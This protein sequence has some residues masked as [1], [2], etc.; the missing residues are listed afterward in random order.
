M[1][2]NVGNLVRELRKMKGLTQEKLAEGICS[3]STIL[4]IEKGERKPDWFT[5]RNIMARLGE[6]PNKF[7]IEIADNEETFVV[8][9]H[10]EWLAYIRECDYESMKK[11]IELHKND[12]RFLN[13]RGR[14][15]FLK[16]KTC[17]Y[18]MG[19]YMDCQIAIECAL[20]SIRLTRP[21]F[22][23]NNI[24]TYFLAPHEIETIN[25]LANAYS[26]HDEPEMSLKI[27]RL[28]KENLGLH[29][30]SFLNFNQFYLLILVNLAE[31]L[32]RLD[33]LN[34][35]LEVCAEGMEVS[36]GCRDMLYYMNFVLTKAECLMKLGNK[37]EG[38]ELFKQVM[39][40]SYA[41]Q[42]KTGMDFNEIAADYM[43]K[44]NEKI[45]LSL[46]WPEG[47]K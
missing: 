40:F 41:T 23:I 28:L 10:L 27:L 24:N 2:F 44:Y 16:L 20:E 30:A 39:L 45:D 35:S 38:K 3:R 12:K 9:K 1:L 19:P 31:D 34:E 5:F 25:N 29:Y 11:E 37:T 18:N 43:E 36:L 17:F 21:D 6:D 47:M 32:N 15:F 42:G 13:G 8:R 33:I 26:N 4:M 14:F 22:E 46:P 7:N